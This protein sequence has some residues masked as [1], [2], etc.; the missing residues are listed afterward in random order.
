MDRQKRSVVKHRTRTAHGSAKRQ[1]FDVGAANVPNG[2]YIGHAKKRKADLIHKAKVKKA[3]YKMLGKESDEVCHG[4]AAA[5]DD[6]AAPAPAHGADQDLG[7]FAPE[8]SDTAH[9]DDAGTSATQP[10][11]PPSAT[12]DS[13]APTVAPERKKKKLPYFY[14]PANTAQAQSKPAVPKRTREDAVQQRGARREKWTRT[15]PS[16]LGRERG[17]PDLGARMQVMLERIQGGSQ[18]P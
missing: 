4:S 3:Y 17:Q 5:G 9:A 12:A 8:G 15:S 18:G 7:R 6:R 14:T 10:R 11:A 13:R 1:G 2:A 16:R